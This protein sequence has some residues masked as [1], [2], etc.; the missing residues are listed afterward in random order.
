MLAEGVYADPDRSIH[1]RG[2]RLDLT[3]TE[4]VRA[5]SRAIQIQWLRNQSVAI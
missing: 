2:L 5:Q 4:P 3:Y 1:I